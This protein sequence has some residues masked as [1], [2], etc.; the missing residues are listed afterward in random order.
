MFLDIAGTLPFCCKPHE[1]SA[2]AIA[3]A[4][5]VV[6][7]AL[8][9]APRAASG[10]PDDAPLPTSMWLMV[11]KG[12]VLG[13]AFSSW[14]RRFVKLEDQSLLLYTDDGPGAD[15]KG[16]LHLEHSS[17]RVTEAKGKTKGPQF[18]FEMTDAN[19]ASTRGGA[20]SFR[21]RGDAR[22]DFFAL[23]PL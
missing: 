13:K 12:G 4:A 1:G 23:P 21:S 9:V 20:A 22:P 3:R 8:R 15:F 10:M 7:A 5:A 19:G 14:K 6:E 16:S 11:R 18:R 2:L 17:L